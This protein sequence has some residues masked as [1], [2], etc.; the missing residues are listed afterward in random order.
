MLIVSG[1]KQPEAA[2]AV[3]ESL[4]RA[5]AGEIEV[6]DR[7]V[8]VGATIGGAVYP[9]DGADAK[10][11]MINADVALY[12]AKAAVRG[13]VLFY[14]AEMGEQVRER[15]ALQADLRA[16]DRKRRT[17]PALSAAKDDQTAKPSASRRCCAGIA[18]SAAR[19]RRRPSFR[20]RKKAA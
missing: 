15:R 8:T 16:A 14:E 6:E 19:C 3:A 17:V 20:S 5:L 12:R 4:L 2:G 10:T 9:A 18:R 1:G 13:T 11:L 7:F